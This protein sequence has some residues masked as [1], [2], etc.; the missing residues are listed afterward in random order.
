MA[1]PTSVFQNHS[2]VSGV[3]RLLQVLNVRFIPFGKRIHGVGIARESVHPVGAV[4]DDAN[5]SWP[6][7]IVV[8]RT[9][10]ADRCL[11]SDVLL[12]YHRVQVAWWSVREKV[13]AVACQQKINRP[14]FALAEEL[15]AL[16]PLG[17]FRGPEGCSS[18]PF[19]R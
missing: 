2:V 11:S 14:S 10:I 8:F 4:G 1:Q 6:I 3:E 7:C 16:E 12:T 18:S 9:A 15:A 5:W 19:A 17:V 13:E